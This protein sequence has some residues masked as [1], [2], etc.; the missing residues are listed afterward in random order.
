M[1]LVSLLPVLLFS[2]KLKFYLLQSLYFPSLPLFLL[3]RSL[4][5]LK[6]ILI[7]SPLMTTEFSLQLDESTLPENESLLLAYVRF[8]KG[9]SLCQKLLF[10]RLLEID[11]K[12]ESV[13][14]AVENYFQKISIPL[15]NIISGATDGAPS[16]VGRHRGFLCYLKKA[17]PKVLT[18]QCDPS[19]TLSGKEF[20]WEAPWILIDC[21]Y[22]SQQNQSECSQFSTVPSAVYWK[23]RRFSMPSSRYRN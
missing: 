9:G 4:S 22:C 3:C 7:S 18:V 1:L 5:P 14:R 10:A 17:V 20:E 21:E 15:T 12:G 16:M 2:R 11:T 19:T 6:F 13:Y 8:I 23:W